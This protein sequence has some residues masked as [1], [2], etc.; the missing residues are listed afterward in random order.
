MAEKQ[1]SWPQVPR[2]GEVFLDHV[3][4]MANDMTTASHAFERLGFLL[5]PYSE[6]AN[7]D[8]VT[9]QRRVQGSA[10]RLA[11]L[12]TGYIEILTAVDGVDSPVSRNIQDSLARYAG[13]HLIA[14]TVN[15]AEAERPRL[16]DAGF[17]LQPTV[18]LRRDVE[19]ADGGDAEVAFTVLRAAF[20]SIPEGRI[21]MLS[22]L[23]PEHMWQDRD[24]TRDNAV[25]G[26]A[27]VVLA[28]ADP[29]VS[30]T[31]L[32]RFIDQAPVA[33]ADG[34]CLPC[35]RGRLRFMNEDTLSRAFAG[36]AAPAIPSTAVIGL[37]SHDLATTREFFEKRGITPM[38][39]ET[40]RLL[41]GPGDGLGAAI[42]FTALEAWLP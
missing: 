15:D 18:R 1:T 34:W 40:D 4:W 17:Q 7:H 2:A 5:T 21:Q 23:T 24:I 32:G 31:R 25:A 39:D 11:M 28:V 36:L 22:H 26:L 20:G 35:D 8:P 13:V 12:E 29:H 19:A 6:H 9:G 14:F 38:I 42:E 27:E 16:S 30:A 33:D 41:V 3:A 10:N 37:A